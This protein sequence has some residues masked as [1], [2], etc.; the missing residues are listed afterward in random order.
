VAPGRH[1]I[2]RDLGPAASAP[3]EVDA[4]AGTSS[5]I[6]LDPPAPPPEPAVSA[7]PPESPA[8]APAPHRTAPTGTWIAFGLAG[9]A[10][11]TALVAGAM[12]LSARSDF[13]SAP[14]VDARDRF[15]RA[16]TITNVA[17]GVAGLAAATGAVLW[18]TAP[19]D[20]PRGLALVLGADGAFV[21]HILTF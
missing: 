2:A 5:V 16:R 4:R 9:A 21:G 20:S 12:T 7:R 17:W 18:L 10:S 1:A 8:A 13:T 11:A 14:S 15:Y 19:S 6:D 3:I